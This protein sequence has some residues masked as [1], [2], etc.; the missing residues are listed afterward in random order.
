MHHTRSD[1]QACLTA[2]MDIE[3]TFLSFWRFTDL[4]RGIPSQPEKIVLY[5]GVLRAAGIYAF[6]IDQYWFC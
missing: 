5:M 2:R 3:S 6:F 1:S 4:E